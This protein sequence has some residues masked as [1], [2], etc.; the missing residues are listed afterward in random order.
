MERVMCMARGLRNQR[1]FIHASRETVMNTDVLQGK[2]REMRG[3]VKEQWAKL[4][5]DDLDT[6]DGKREQLL[7]LLQQRYGFAREKAEEEY[8]RFADRWSENRAGHAD[9]PR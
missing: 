5:D 8:K 4:T 2:W 7:G 1:G 9:T 6:I 3:Q